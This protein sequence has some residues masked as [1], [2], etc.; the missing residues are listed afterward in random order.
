MYTLHG[1][2]DWGSQVIH[3]A[4]AEL[5]QPFTF[6]ALDWDAGD[7]AAPAFLA[8][9]PFA[10]VPVLETPDGP[11]FETLAILLYLCERHNALAPAPGTPGRPAFLTALALI[12]NSVHPHAMALIHPERPGGE[13]SQA[14]VSA[15][16]HE[17]LAQEIGF[18]NDLATLGKGGL[19]AEQPTIAGLYLAMLMR[20]MAA[21]PA[22]KQHAIMPSDYPALLALLRG[23]EA[24]PAVA[25]V[26]KAEGLPPDAF[27][28][29]APD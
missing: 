12:T 27:S 3:L 28:A 19:S 29:P 21:F 4:L 2:A 7:F 25:A 22:Y 13:A 8:L 11:V 23:L 24:R 18:L 26:L 9:N 6:K 17:R 20:W 1:V 14:A 5:G 10:R 15:V 16:T